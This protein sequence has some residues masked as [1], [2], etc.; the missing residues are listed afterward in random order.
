MLH[1]T[2]DVSHVE[3]KTIFVCFISTIKEKKR[4]D[5]REQ[6]LG[7]IPVTDTTGASLTEVVLAKLTDLSLP[8]KILHGQGYN[9]GSNMKG[10][11]VGL[12]RHIFDMNPRAFY[13]PS[14]SH[15][16]NL[17]INAAPKRCIS[18]TAFFCLVQNLYVL[19]S[20]STQC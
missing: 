16:L 13:V 1:C 14:S 9:N 4:F 19:F 15:P 17:V 3:E 8:V 11:S 2:P 5:I 18:A 6:F 7:F 10:K 20:E 12:Q